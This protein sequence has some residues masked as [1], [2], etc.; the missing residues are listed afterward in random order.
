MTILLDFDL[1]PNPDQNNR[2]LDIY[3]QLKSE[4]QKI[5]NYYK[6]QM[7]KTNSFITIIMNPTKVL[8]IQITPNEGEIANE[9]RRFI[10]EDLNI[11]ETANKIM[12][13]NK[14]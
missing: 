5:D 6:D 10:M 9:I 13:L 4:L 3:L 12:T 14:N 7:K 1:Y 11:S 8:D 2:V